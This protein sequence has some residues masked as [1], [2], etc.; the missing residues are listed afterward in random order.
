MSNHAMGARLAAVALVTLIPAAASAQSVADFYKGKTI[1]LLVGSS[2]GG[3]YALYGRALAEF[4][5]RHI[6]GKPTMIAKFTGGQG[7]GLD[8]ANSMSNTVKPDGLTIGMT[9]QTIVL[10]QVLL[11]KFAKYDARK[12]YWLGNVSP[13]RNMMMVSDKSK[14]QTLADTK[15]FEVIVGATGPSSPTAILPKTLNKLYGSK[16]KVVFGYKGI[17]GF[18]LALRRGEIEGYGGSWV[19]V[20]TQLPTELKEGKVKALVFASRTREP[21]NP[22]VPTLVE[23]LPDEKAKK[24]A[25]FLAAESDYG[26]SLFLGPG[27]PAERA[28]ALRKAFEDTMK[29]ADFLAMA[30][31]LRI[32]VEPTS[33]DSL[34]A[35]TQD[36]VATP[37]EILDLAK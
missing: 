26:R 10:H 15:K 23:V 24:V 11:P 12:W 18:K 27:V 30:K 13:I 20:V 4:M 19:A 32:P 33:G 16:F 2:A 28:A 3:S 1:T 31:K 17:G 34:A 37:T 6:P 14:A 8:V 7:G 35:L 22:D 21:T 5:P 25:N 36:I 9:Q 29:D